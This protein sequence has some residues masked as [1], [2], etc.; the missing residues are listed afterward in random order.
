[1][2]QTDFT[3]QREMTDILKER[4]KSLKYVKK[5][6]KAREQNE[7]ENEGRSCSF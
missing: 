4:S 3:C 6:L 5:E 2:Q 7:A 1:M